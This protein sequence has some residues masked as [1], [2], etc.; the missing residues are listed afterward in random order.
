LLSRVKPTSCLSREDIFNRE[1][2]SNRRVE[3]KA[4]AEPFERADEKVDT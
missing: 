3:R 4:R 1:K 2:K